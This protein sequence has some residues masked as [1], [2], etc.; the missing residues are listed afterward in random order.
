MPD[1]LVMVSDNISVGRYFEGWIRISRSRIQDWRWWH[2]G[3][4]GGPPMLSQW[5]QSSIRQG[6]VSSATSSHFFLL[7]IIIRMIG[8]NHFL[9][10]YGILWNIRMARGMRLEERI[11]MLM[12]ILNPRADG[13]DG[14]RPEAAIL[15]GVRGWRCP[16]NKSFGAHLMHLDDNQDEG[17]SSS[18]VWFLLAPASRSRR[19]QFRC[20]T[21]VK[22]SLLSPSHECLEMPHLHDRGIPKIIQDHQQ[23]PVCCSWRWSSFRDLMLLPVL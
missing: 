17:I 14:T 4:D 18:S 5:L 21:R 8:R 7:L 15:Y 11:K 6:H 10:F 2:E 23:T 19:C 20:Q 12:T 1:C 9:V 3:M 16:S 13:T 22:S